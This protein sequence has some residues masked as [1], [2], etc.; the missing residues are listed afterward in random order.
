M[1]KLGAHGSLL[2]R[3]STKDEYLFYL[4]QRSQRLGEEAKTAGILY[5]QSLSQGT[6]FVGF[7][8]PMEVFNNGAKKRAAES[9]SAALSRIKTLA[10][11]EIDEIKGVL[12]KM[13]IVEAELIQQLALTDR[14]IADSAGL[15]S[16]QKS[17]SLGKKR[18]SLKFPFDGEVWF[19]EI[20]NYNV[21]VA[22]GCQVKKGI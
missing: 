8:G 22:K 15:S 1:S 3:L 5:S 4:A 19:D 10:A 2:P 16:I 14:M 20:S 11:I 6:A 9:Q 18:F 7:Q 12:Q 17:S 13:Q 21:N